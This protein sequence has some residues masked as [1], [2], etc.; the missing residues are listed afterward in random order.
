[1]HR[2]RVYGLAVEAEFPLPELVPAEALPPTGE[3]APAASPFG[4]PSEPPAST[5]VLAEARTLATQQDVDVQIRFGT[6]ASAA[7]R[8]DDP[9]DSGSWVQRLGPT[10]LLSQFEGVARFVV[11]NGRAVL[12]EPQS[13]ADPA[14]VR[15][16]LLGP[17]LAQ[18][19]W[20]RAKFVLHG[21][22]LR[23]GTRQLAFLGVSGAGKST[24]ALALHRA[25]HTLVCD[26]VAALEW[27]QRPVLVHPAL[28]RMRA[29][30]DSLEQVG[31]NREGLA[32]AHRDLDKWLLPARRFADAPL[33]LDRVYVLTDGERLAAESLSKAEGMMELMRHTYHA[34]QYT[35]L[36]GVQEHMKAA[37]AIANAVSIKRL[38]RPKDWSRLSA[39]V[40]FIEEEAAEP[41]FE[42][43]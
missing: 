18:V 43:S 22:V 27:N 2:Y 4:S 37:G 3:P 32:R 26:D 28:P 19:L 5:S 34:E 35:G 6:A 12:V 17:V 11:L 39:L 20:Q 21:C 41:D 36:F 16:L 30:A 10:V 13:E 42:A 14:Y 1:M 7:P 40:R 38:V 23:V 24:L 31:E 25:G 8:S 9:A 15:H 33:S 29:H